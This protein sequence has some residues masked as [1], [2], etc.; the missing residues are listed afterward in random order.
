MDFP[1]NA[2]EL[3]LSNDVYIL[4]FSLLI[5]P[6]FKS[7]RKCQTSLDNFSVASLTYQIPAHS[8]TLFSF[9]DYTLVYN[10]EWIKELTEFNI[11][12]TKCHVIPE[13]NMS[14]NLD[15]N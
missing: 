9:M 14:I 3:L 15:Q 6:E 2:Y 7:Q 11:Y 8:C 13:Y 5:A 4:M 10:T 12:I 1:F